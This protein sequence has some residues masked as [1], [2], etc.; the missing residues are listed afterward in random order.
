MS[1]DNN[2]SDNIWLDPLLGFKEHMVLTCL[3]K[4]SFIPSIPIQCLL[5]VRN[6]RTE[7]QLLQRNY[8]FL[9]SSSL[10]FPNPFTRTS[11]L[12]EGSLRFSLLLNSS[13]QPGEHYQFRRGLEHLSASH[14]GALPSIHKRELLMAN[15]T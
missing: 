1:W 7:G 3:N 12:T 15:Q 6:K 11:Q 10:S 8:F 4:H 5:Y 9:L 2:L 13:H 14:G